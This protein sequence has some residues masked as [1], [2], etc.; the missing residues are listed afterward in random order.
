VP[1]AGT[2]ATVQ[3]VSLTR[4]DNAPPR[5]PFLQLVDLTGGWFVMGA[6]DGP[7]PEDGEG[8]PRS[9]FVDP[10][11]ISTTTVTNKSFAAFADATGY[12]TVAEELGHSFVFQHLVPP[13]LPEP[14]SAAHAPWW[15]LVNGACWHAPEG[16][17]SAIGDRPGHPAV[18]IALRDAIAYCRWSGSRLPT[19][20]EWE[21]AA[22][23]GLEGKPFPW[24]DE[25]D[26]GGRVM[27]NTWQG[28]F[29]GDRSGG[30]G[31]TGTV[32]ARSFSAN[33]VGLYNMTGNAWEWTG[34]RFSRLHSPR[35]VKNPTGPLNGNSFVAKG[36]SYLCHRSYCARY[37]TSSRQ[38]LAPDTT[39][40]NVGFRI[41]GAQGRR[42]ARASRQSG[43]EH[44]PD[45]C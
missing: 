37:R 29:P 33:G 28:P 12:R 14:P 3:P 42:Q 4:P 21:F 1:G 45:P 25:Q 17:G 15:R 27:S 24:G 20:A 39:A 23:G 40:G 13:H 35:P 10:F 11:S 8:P 9:V 5:P 41:A 34:D 6:A 36:G 32:P 31:C 26:P 7:H 19:E 43:I 18:H 44:N 16:E 2:A 22:R 30:D 38:A